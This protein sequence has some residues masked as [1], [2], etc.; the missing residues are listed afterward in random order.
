MN[1][2]LVINDS[3]VVKVVKVLKYVTLTFNG[4]TPIV[5]SK[6]I[7]GDVIAS[8]VVAAKQGIQSGSIIPY[9]L[10]YNWKNGDSIMPLLVPNIDV[11]YSPD[12]CQIKVPAST[13]QIV[14]SPSGTQTQVG[15][16]LINSRDPLYLRGETMDGS[17]KRN[18]TI[19]NSMTAAIGNTYNLNLIFN[20]NG[21]V[22]QPG[23]S[24]TF[25]VKIS[26][27]KDRICTKFLGYVNISVYVFNSSGPGE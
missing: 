22:I 27:Y 8:P 6:Q 9:D 26:F 12:W 5:T 25:T 10:L 17:I 1:D 19:E 2:N 7:P 20:I 23:A 14:Y 24:K 18:V 11:T 15:S 13:L 16:Y 3:N 21:I 4:I